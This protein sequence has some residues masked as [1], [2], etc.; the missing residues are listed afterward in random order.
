MRER[1]GAV[2]TSPSKF[3]SERMNCPMKL[4]PLL[5]LCLSLLFPAPLSAQVENF[6]GQDL[7]DRVFDNQRLIGVDFTGANLSGASFRRAIVR[8]SNFKGANLKG[9]DFRYADVRACQFA[10]AE[11]LD[12]TALRQGLFSATTT[13]P[14]G[15]DGEKNGARLL[16][17]VTAEAPPG[18]ADTEK[19][20]LAAEIEKMV[21]S[22]IKHDGKDLSDKDFSDSSLV[23]AS[24]GAAKL[25]RTRFNRSDLRGALFRAAEIEDTQFDGADLAYSDFRGAILT[26]PS[27]RD[28]SMIGADLS[29]QVLHLN[30]WEGYFTPAETKLQLDFRSAEHM[31]IAEAR[32][33]KNGNLNLR[34]AILQRSVIYGNLEGVNFRNA[35]LRGANLAHATNA[36][37][38]LFNGAIYDSRTNFGDLNISKTSAVKGEELIYEEP[39]L[40]SEAP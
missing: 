36:D 26:R 25:T 29:D 34:S 4:L 17:D 12:P 9:A 15:V 40:D 37:P 2:M 14:P 35:D 6:A 31:S 16:A 11:N 28:C 30:G 19:K 38:S 8:D 10:E 22:G 5:F 1:Q 23:K 13:F 27:F 32:R 3:R 21:S 7:R 33:L 18:P 39:A 24:F 20:G